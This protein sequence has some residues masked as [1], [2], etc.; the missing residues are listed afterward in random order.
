MPVL[1]RGDRSRVFRDSG[2]EDWTAAYGVF[3]D[4]ARNVGPNYVLAAA[5]STSCI[6]NSNRATSNSDSSIHRDS[7]S[8]SPPA[9]KPPAWEHP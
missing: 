1:R 5:I 4:E 8:Y 2:A 3:R 9:C 7:K 6:R